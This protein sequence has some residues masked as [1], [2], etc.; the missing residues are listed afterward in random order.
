M[1]HGVCVC[2]CT[3]IWEAH[4]NNAYSG[5]FGW[6][7]QSMV[8]FCVLVVVSSSISLL[9]FCLLLIVEKGLDV[10]N[11]SGLDISPFSPV[12]A[13]HVLQLCLVHRNLGLLCLL[14]NLTLLSLCEV[15]GNFLCSEV[16]FISY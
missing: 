12:F 10:S 7:L 3:H 13:L 9:I 14:G 16:Y 1:A 2:V 15:F 4:E 11:H 6:S 8:R 5:G